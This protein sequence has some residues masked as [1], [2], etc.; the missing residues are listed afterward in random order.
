M[1]KY[2]RIA[3]EVVVFLL[4]V[5]LFVDFSGTIA[6]FAGWL[7]K[8][9]LLPAVLSLNV[10]VLVLLVIAT[11]LFGRLYCSIVC[12]LGMFQDIF[13]AIGLK[14]VRRN[15]YSFRKENPWLR[16]AVLIVYIVMLVLGIIVAY[17]YACRRSGTNGL[18]ADNMTDVALYTVIAGI[19][20]ASAATEVDARTAASLA[21]A[22]SLAL[23]CGLAIV[24]AFV[25]P[26]PS[27]EEAQSR[28]QAS[29]AGYDAE[30][31][32]GDPQIEIVFAPEAAWCGPCAVATA[33]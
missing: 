12:P 22:A 24:A 18:T 1:L 17:F 19:V 26:R 6:P 32:A 31:C 8:I 3:V 15:K 2:L 21:A 29:F 25:L 16:G 5:A 9:Q 33:E 30:L 7:A 4:I 28:R 11:L 20:G 13:A 10:L 14:T 27:D 23:V